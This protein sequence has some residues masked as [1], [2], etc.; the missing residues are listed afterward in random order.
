[1]TAVLSPADS[2]GRR[3][4]APL[5]EPSLD[6][7][8]PSL[9]GR[10]VPPLLVGW[11]AIMVTASWGDNSALTHLATGRRIISGS[12]PRS[13]P[14]TFTARGAS[15]TVQSWL[16]SAAMALAERVDATFGVAVW[17][18]ALIMTVA[19][20][21]WWLSS[22][23]TSLLGR[24][25]AVIPFF[26]VGQ[27][28]WSERPLMIGLIGVAIVMAV[29][30]SRLPAWV[31]IPVGWIWVN[32]H[33]SFVL[34]PVILGAVLIGEALDRGELRSIRLRPLAWCVGG[35]ATGVVGPLGVRALTFPL[36]A[37]RRS[38]DFASI[39]EWQAPRFTATTDRV[40]LLMTLLAVA[41]LVRRPTW[42]HA[43]L[44]VV[45][46]GLALTSQRNMA[47]ASLCLIVPIAA[48]LTS[49]GTLQTARTPR[50]AS[51]LGATALAATAFVSASFGA[52]GYPTAALNTL[53]ARQQL[54]QLAAPDFVGNFVTN[55]WSSDIAVMFDDRVD[56]QPPSV[57][58]DQ[59]MLYGARPG[60]EKMLRRNNVDTIL[61][62]ADSP[63]AGALAQSDQWDIVW[64]DGHWLIAQRRL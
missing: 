22:A 6:V 5:D 23:S 11:V 15:W 18:A 55:A 38:S 16:P 26:V 2:I 64:T 28:Q 1:V 63:L 29:A 8:K 50:V 31:L 42:R 53:A 52:Q 48:S 19:A 12:F 43:M 60:W 21:G 58:R 10:V 17:R 7:A 57:V 51:V 33:G 41:L 30:E 24:L 35:L 32:S 25:V 49:M 37:L 4:D 36:V 46:T 44:I 59:R 54:S 27:Q 47:V 3:Q 20:L 56:M 9:I 39:V 61:W 40:F 62:Q 45:V 14:Y 13:D 34:A